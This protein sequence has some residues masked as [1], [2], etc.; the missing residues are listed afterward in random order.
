MDPGEVK[1]G[2]QVHYVK[3]VKTVGTLYKVEVMDV[4]Y[5]GTRH[6]RIRGQTYDVEEDTKV[7]HEVKHADY[8]PDKSGA[9]AH[10]RIMLVHKMQQLRARAMSLGF[11]LK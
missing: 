7:S 6:E 10:A 9:L 11:F 4:M 3:F 1:V 2:D 8:W 5:P